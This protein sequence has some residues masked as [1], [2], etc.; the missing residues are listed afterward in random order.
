MVNC[1]CKENNI[2]KY[3]HHSGCVVVRKFA[4]ILKNSNNTLCT[5]FLNFRNRNKENLVVGEAVFDDGQVKRK[6]RVFRLVVLDEVY[7]RLELFNSTILKV[8]RS[9]LRTSKVFILITRHYH[10]LLT[11]ACA[12]ASATYT[13]TKILNLIQVQKVTNH[14]EELQ[15]FRPPVILLGIRAISPARRSIFSRKIS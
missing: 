4:R 11:Y 7:Y 14:R 5:Q 8:T 13:A 10:R 15:F 9:D 12:Y 2:C 6:I 3:V 1:S